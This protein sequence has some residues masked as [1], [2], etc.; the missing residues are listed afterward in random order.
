MLDICSEIGTMESKFS[1]IQDPGFKQN[2][3]F[4]IAAA[5]AFIGLLTV[6]HACIFV[7]SEMGY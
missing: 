3:G 1:R 4:L 5:G 2:T 6:H 7:L